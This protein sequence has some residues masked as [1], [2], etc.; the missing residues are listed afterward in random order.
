MSDS[1]SERPLGYRWLTTTFSTVTLA[2]GLIFPITVHALSYK[3]T[4][5]IESTPSGATIIANGVQAGV[6]PQTLKD[7]RFNDDAPLELMV[8]AKGYES[9]SRSVTKIEAKEYPGG[10]KAEIALSF[11]LEPLE[12]SVPVR[13]EA[14]AGARFTVNGVSVSAE[15]T[16]PFTRKDSKSDWS[17]VTVRAERA[18]HEPAVR[19]IDDTQVDALPLDGER[20][21]LQLNPVEVRRTMVLRVEVNEEG[22]QVLVNSTN[23]YDAGPKTPPE[24]TLE[25]IR[26]GEG[27]PWSTNVVTVAK[28]GFEYRPPAPAEARPESTTNLTWECATNLQGKLAVLHFQA[29]KHLPVPW[30]RVVVDRGEVRLEET[31]VLSAITP[32]GQVVSFNSFLEKDELFI[33]DRFGVVSK[34]V[35]KGKPSAA[36]IAV[37][38]RAI[39]DDMPAEIVGSAIVMVEPPPAR[40][41]KKL[42]TMGDQ[43]GIYDLQPCITSDGE[44]VYFSSNRGD[45]G[46]YRIFRVPVKSSRL[47]AE[48]SPPQPGNDVQPTTYTAND[49]QTR[50]AFTR[51]PV[52]AAVRGEPKIMIQ[53]RD[54][55]FAQVCEAG[56]S[57][58]WSHDGTKMLYVSANGR[59]C[60]MDPETGEEKGKLDVGAAPA[61][62][63]GDKQIIF[64]KPVANSYALSIINWDGSGDPLNPILDS[65][66]YSFPAVSSFQENGFLYFIS[67]RQ[68]QQR[69]AESWGLYYIEWNR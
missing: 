41:K 7:Y 9:Q 19:E 29:L 27:Q 20:R 44:L 8:S 30:R 28:E 39:R 67:N 55:T 61:W 16:L 31:S 34:G 3:R 17:K 14:G 50:L 18:D 69:N 10:S 53:G 15:T 6:T 60:I 62:M 65:S 64:A 45:G 58:A 48:V 52:K 57:P 13:L 36:V 5:R 46:Q 40:S 47:V 26:S 63:P 24:V 32:D 25:F 42:A 1:G 43:H 35:E 4:V 68:A 33:A 21:K 22:T 54:G 37:A 11:K 12:K 59:I 56:H 49:G 38:K 66:F 2:A 51:Y 23:K